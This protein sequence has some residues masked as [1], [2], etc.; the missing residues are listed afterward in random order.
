LERAELGLLGGQYKVSRFV[1]DEITDTRRFATEVMA[2][3]DR[4]NI[5]VAE[6]DRRAREALEEMVA[7]QSRQAIAVWDRLGRYFARAYK[8]DVD[9][10]RF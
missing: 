3:A 7:T 9:T 4:L 1:V 2:L 10:S 6:V 8:L 5:A